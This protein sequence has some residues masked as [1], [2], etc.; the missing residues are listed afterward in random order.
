MAADRAS[1]A[2]LR[3][4]ALSL[5]RFTAEDLERACRAAPK[6]VTDAL[7]RWVRSGFVRSEPEARY[8]VV[9][10]SEGAGAGTREG[11][12]WRAM[13]LLGTFSVVDLLAH[14]RTETVAIPDRF[15]R[16]Y[17]R[18]LMTA[19]YLRVAKPAARG[20]EAVYRIARNTGP[21]APVIRRLAALVD[22]NLGGVVW[23]PIPVVGDAS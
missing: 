14:S 11:N 6:R 19:G 22:P 17:T 3:R 1:E 16:D 20:R 5:G 23:T 8:A 10:L 12:L 7:I 4:V 15:A 13:R 18:T 21:A 2:H 9:E